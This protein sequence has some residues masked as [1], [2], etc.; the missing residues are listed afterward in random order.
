LMSVR[1][2]QIEI[3]LTVG[4]MPPKRKVAAAATSR[5]RQRDA[6]DE[7]RKIKRMEVDLMLEA[8]SVEGEWASTLRRMRWLCRAGASAGGAAPSP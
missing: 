5:K 4:N 7:E 3:A 1:G 6:D 2:C 8:A